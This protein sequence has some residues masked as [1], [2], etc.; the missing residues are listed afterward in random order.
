MLNLQGSIQRAQLNGQ[1][2]SSFLPYGIIGA[3]YAIAID[4]VARNLYLGN[5]GASTIEVSITIL[6]LT[7]KNILS[8]DNNNVSFI[9]LVYHKCLYLLLDLFNAD[10]AG[11]KSS[12]FIRSDYI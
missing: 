12:I 2:R 1:N 5:I 4:W 6:N 7:Q 8:R 10:L 11:W 9:S 3:P